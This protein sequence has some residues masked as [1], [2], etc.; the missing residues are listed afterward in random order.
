LLESV[1][2]R[3][4]KVSAE[5]VTEFYERNKEEF[6][7]P[8]EVRASHILIRFPEKP[9]SEDRML[10]REKAEALLRELRAGADFAAMA[11]K[12]SEDA[13]TARRGGDRGY[14]ARGEMDEA[15][16]QVAFS[17]KPGQLSNLVSTP[18]GFEIITVTGRRQA[19]YRP[20][21]EVRDLIHEVL[22]KSERQERQAALVRQLTARANV[23]IL[24]P[25]K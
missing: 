17:L 21:P 3:S 10:A 4:I 15:F 12:H 2:Y 23:E 20:L 19:G 5:E 16:E 1:V 6:R 7:H 9:T 18:Y 25:V 24:A 13:V 22:T 14:F 8:E 11:R